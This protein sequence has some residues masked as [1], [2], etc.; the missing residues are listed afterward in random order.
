MSVQ[1]YTPIRGMYVNVGS[2]DYVKSEDYDRRER[3]LAEAIGLLGEARAEVVAQ[4]EFHGCDNCNLTSM[5]VVKRI[6][7]MLLQGTQLGTSENP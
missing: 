6:D 4:A 7:A 1:R 5:D 2:G 3:E